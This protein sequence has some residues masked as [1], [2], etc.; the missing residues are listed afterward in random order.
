[1]YVHYLYAY[2]GMGFPGGSAVKDLPATQEPQ[3]TRVR[4]LGQ[5]GSP[6][7]VTATH[8]SILA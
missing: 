7:K 5:E 1:M 8:S 4:C 6:E 2:L 3:E